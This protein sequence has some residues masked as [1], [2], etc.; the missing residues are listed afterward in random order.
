M[1][2][3]PKD[4]YATQNLRPEDESQRAKES[5]KIGL[6]PKRDVLAVFRRIANPKPRN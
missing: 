3:P 1:A 2:R 4:D 6:L 5:T